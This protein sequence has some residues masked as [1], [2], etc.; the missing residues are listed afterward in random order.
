VTKQESIAVYSKLTGE[1]DWF[2]PVGVKVLA[3]RLE[4][5]GVS[6]DDMRMIANDL[7]EHVSRF[8]G[9][10]T[11]GIANQASRCLSMRTRKHKVAELRSNL[12]HHIRHY[13]VL[14]EGGHLKNWNA[15]RN[16]A[17]DI[18]L[19]HACLPLVDILEAIVERFTRYEK[20]RKKAT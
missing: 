7:W 14:N 9:A 20:K 15:G 13:E 19:W 8:I 11:S 1:T 18:S 3:D 10:T 12:K 4:E 5:A 17:G 2:S 6:G 16:F